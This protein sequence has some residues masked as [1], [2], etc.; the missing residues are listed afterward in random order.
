MDEEIIRTELYDVLRAKSYEQRAKS[1]EQRAKSY[2]KQAA[3]TTNSRDSLEQETI[4]ILKAAQAMLLD[5]TIEMSEQN[6]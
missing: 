6:Y 5:S 4:L 1:Y 2:E 3:S